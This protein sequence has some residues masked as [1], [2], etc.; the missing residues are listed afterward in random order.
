MIKK[1]YFCVPAKFM[2]PNFFSSPFLCFKQGSGFAA[3]ILLLSFMFCSC[4]ER[5]VEVPPGILSKDKMIDVLVDVHLAEAA[6]MN[7]GITTKELNGIMVGKYDDVMKKH[8]ITF[9]QFKKSFDYYLQHPDQLDEI[10]QEV[11]NR[12]TALEGKSRVKRPVSKRGV[13]SI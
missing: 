8:T 6:P 3:F 5:K 10:Y 12:L 11:V 7:H 2:M 4:K 9:E 1:K 13:D